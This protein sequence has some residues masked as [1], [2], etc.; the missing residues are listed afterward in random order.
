[1][2]RFSKHSEKHNRSYKKS[3]RWRSIKG[4]ILTLPFILTG[5]EATRDFLTEI[6]QQVPIVRDIK[7]QPPVAPAQ[8]TSAAE[9][10][11]QIWQQI[12]NIRKQQGLSELR[13][14]ATLA[15]VARKY[16]QKMAERNFFAHVS[17]DGDSVADRVRAAKVFYWMVGE[18]LFRS[19]NITQPV[20]AAVEGWMNSPGHR[21]NI[22]RSEYRETGIGVWRVGNS[23]WVTQVFLR[24]IP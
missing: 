13:Y 1:M 10:E 21:A 23:Y 15:S 16:S 19:A 22:L 5:C 2:K 20:P 8:S 11:Q 3:V 4:L 9:M 6:G 7:E 14:N 12:N 24:S 18:N 17:P